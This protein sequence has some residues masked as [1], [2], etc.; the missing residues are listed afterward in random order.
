MLPVLIGEQIDLDPHRHQLLEQELARVRDQH[1]T[2]VGAITDI[3]DLMRVRH[4]S[5]FCA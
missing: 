1:A 4:R 5:A 2:D 3:A